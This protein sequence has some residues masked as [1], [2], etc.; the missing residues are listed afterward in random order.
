MPSKLPFF[1]GK[2]LRE[3][4]VFAHVL[5]IRLR[6]LCHLPFLF[7]HASDKFTKTLH[8]EQ[9]NER[10]F[11]AYSEVVAVIIDIFVGG[12][13]GLVLFHFS[14]RS[15]FVLELL[16]YGGHVLH[17]DVLTESTKW[18]MGV[19][20]GLKLNTALTE[21][22]GTLVLAVLDLWNL[23]TTQLAALEPTIVLLV[24][25][26]GIMGSSIVLAVL[27]D[28]VHC[29]T[30]H[31]LLIYSVFA[32]VHSFMLKVIDSLWHLFRGRKRNILR[33]RVD[34]LDFSMER[35]LLGTILFTILVFLFP[36]F[37]VYYLFFL[38]VWMTIL[39]FQAVIWLLLTI[40]TTV[41]F[42]AIYIHMRGSPSNKCLPGA[43]RLSLCQPILQKDIHHSSTSDSKRNESFGRVQQGTANGNYGFTAATSLND[44]SPKHFASQTAEGK[45]NSGNIYSN[46][47]NARY[48]DVTHLR[49]KGV[50]VGF[51][52]LLQKFFSYISAWYKHYHP[53]RMI[54]SSLAGKFIRPL[55]FL[56]R[57]K[58]IIL[59][60]NLPSQEDI[61]KCLYD[62]LKL[63]YITSQNV[64]S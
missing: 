27:V 15:D 44:T 54:Q 13:V 53:V 29:V 35:L 51:G 58:S 59:S 46:A 16:H 10:H 31:I 49:L 32:S 45:S 57:S 37:A 23:V 24:G 22:I 55:P 12:F 40:M 8:I 56:L 1:G 39:L 19:P 48:T 42:Y 21:W 38:T 7:Y 41:P 52:L 2:A 14:K 4:S 11:K 25:A 33:N 18:L 20:A 50:P 34:T 5:D 9:R 36:T 28:M 6:T 63:R 30:V 62:N 3:L 47:T 60:D 64:F 26:C 17:M 61:K 43:I